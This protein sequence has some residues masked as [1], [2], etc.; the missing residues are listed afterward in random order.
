MWLWDEASKVDKNSTKGWSAVS[1]S[2][3]FVVFPTD[4]N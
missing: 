2:C 3:E 1:W 4:F